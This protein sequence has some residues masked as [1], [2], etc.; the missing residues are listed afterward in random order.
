MERKGFAKKCDG[1]DE[2][3]IEVFHIGD[4]W[5]LTIFST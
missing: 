2:E 4:E 1:E 3:I 5:K